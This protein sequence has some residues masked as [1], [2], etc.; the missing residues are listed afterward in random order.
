[1]ANTPQG[2]PATKLLTRPHTSA[3]ASA[4]SS[5]GN[6]QAGVQNTHATTFNGRQPPTNHLPGFKPITAS[7]SCV[8]VSDS[9]NTSSTSPSTLK[10]ARE[11]CNGQDGQTVSRQRRDG[12]PSPTEPDNLPP[13]SVRYNFPIAR[14]AG[15]LTTAT[16][17]HAGVAMDVVKHNGSVTMYQYRDEV[18]ARLDDGILQVCMQGGTL[19]VHLYGG[20]FHVWIHGGN[21]T[22]HVHGGTTKIHRRGNLENG[23]KGGEI[24]VIRH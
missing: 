6:G 12:E 21:T 7:S 18:T 22:V 11:E 10:R 5:N 20:L 9:S 17:D 14:E 23:C 8:T 4:A 15:L 24:K 1:M 13:E 2:P 19:D 16:I 3:S